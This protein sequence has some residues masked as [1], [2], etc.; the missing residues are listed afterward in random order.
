MVSEGRSP[1]ERQTRRGMT[2]RGGQQSDLDFG[3]VD[4]G[5]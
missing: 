2:E 4:R 3:D 1:G 5:V